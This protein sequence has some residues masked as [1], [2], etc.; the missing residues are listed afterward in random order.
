[1]L[2]FLVLTHATYHT[3]I[4]VRRVHTSIHRSASTRFDCFFLAL[5]PP[6][7]HITKAHT[8]LRQPESREH[9]STT[10]AAQSALCKAAKHVLR[11]YL[12]IRARNRK[13]ADDTSSIYRKHSTPQSLGDPWTLVGLQLVIADENITLMGNPYFLELFDFFMFCF[14]VL[15]RFFSTV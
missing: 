9:L 3:N 13:H 10:H 1:M 12:P 5:A 14:F 8:E 6:P 2:C 15:F 4:R 11:T 7:A